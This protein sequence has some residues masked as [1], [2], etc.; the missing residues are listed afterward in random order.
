MEK[1]VADDVLRDERIPLGRRHLPALAHGA[2]PRGAGRFSKVARP[3]RMHRRSTW[4]TRMSSR[5]AYA[6]MRASRSASVRT[7]SAAPFFDLGF[8]PA[9]I[10]SKIV[11]VCNGVKGG[12]E[13]LTI[14][15]E[16]RILPGVRVNVYLG[17]SIH[18]LR[19]GRV[20]QFTPKGRLHAIRRPGVLSSVRRN[21]V[22]K[23]STGG[24]SARIFVGLKV[25]RRTKW[26]EADVA[27]IIWEV[28]EAQ[29]RNPDASLLS[30]LGIYKDRRGRRI[31]EESVQVV[32]LD[33]EGLVLASF[34]QEMQSLAEALRERLAQELVVLEIQERGV[35]HSIYSVTP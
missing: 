29:G 33:L 4:L 23:L 10:G 12:C 8:L 35:V 34:V 22:E 30:Q 24:L 13:R 16:R 21:P 25:G 2:I 1:R 5:S 17:E 7:K 6:R 18:H 26:K 19:D 14:E 11:S 15:R 20:R 3:M 27:K 32:I 28:R 9:A 31:V